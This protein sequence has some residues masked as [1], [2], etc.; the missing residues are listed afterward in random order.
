MIMDSKRRNM[1]RGSCSLVWTARLCGYCWHA[2]SR[3]GHYCRLRV[4]KYQKT[5]ESLFFASFLILYYAVLLKRDPRNITIT[6]I[7]LYIWIAAFACDELGEFQDAGTLFYATD[8][9]NMS[10]YFRVFPSNSSSDQSKETIFSPVHVRKWDRANSRY[11]NA[12]SWNFSGGILSP[13][14]SALRFS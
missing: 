2:L 12:D 9:W 3:C 5:I 14:P 7:L 13:L 6:E 11:D 1:N 4:P 10:V 8:F